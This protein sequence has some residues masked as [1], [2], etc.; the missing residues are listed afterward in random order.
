M[1]RLSFDLTNGFRTISNYTL[2]QDDKTTAVTFEAGQIEDLFD[3]RPVNFATIELE[4]KKFYLQIDTGMGSDTVAEA[5]FLAILGHN[6][7]EANVMFRVI[8]DDHITSNNMVS[9]NSVT[10][11]TAVTGLINAAQSTVTV[12]AG[13]NLENGVNSSVTE[14][15]LNDDGATLFANHIGGIVKIVSM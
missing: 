3:M 5:N 8:H 6:M 1:D 15:C 10:A 2:V 9:A 14:I 13:T 4:N 12:D 7:E 11:S